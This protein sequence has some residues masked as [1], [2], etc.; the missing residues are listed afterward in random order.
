GLPHV[1]AHDW[2]LGR[3]FD[4]VVIALKRGRYLEPSDQATAEPVVVIN[5]TMARR[6]W[7]GQDPVGQRIAWGSAS[8]NSRWLRIVGI[9]ADIK[10]GPLSSETVPQTYQ[11]WL[12]VSDRMIADN[13]VAILRSMRVIVRTAT[14]PESLVSSVR[15]QIR[16]L[17]PA[18]PL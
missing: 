6:F 3:Y 11:P 18:L 17:D 13:V 2:V 15:A 12:Q 5:E 16:E 14:E 10:Q 8:A 7:P 9:V 1:V 4:S